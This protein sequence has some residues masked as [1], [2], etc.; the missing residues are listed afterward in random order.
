M[1]ISLNGRERT[2]SDWR[3]LFASV[4]ERFELDFEYWG[5]SLQWFIKATW[6]PD[7]KASSS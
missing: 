2:E 1:L 4:D 5:G 7:C 6:Q 3:R